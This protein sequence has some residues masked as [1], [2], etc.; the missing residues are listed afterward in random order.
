MWNCWC[1]ISHVKID[2]EFYNRIIR[3]PQPE[4]TDHLSLTKNVISRC[5][6][7][8]WPIIYELFFKK[9]TKHESHQASRASFHSKGQFAG[10]LQKVSVMEK[11]LRDIPTKCKDGSC[12]DPGTNRTTIKV[13][14]DI[15]KEMQYGLGT[16]W[17]C[18]IL[19]TVLTIMWFIRKYFFRYSVKYIEVKWHDDCG[20]L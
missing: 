15:S 18:G 17:V 10:Y 8:M 7:L 5:V 20:L 11:R 9:E 14:F 16:Q 19:L 12:L 13:H 6:C 4:P 3:Q 2:G 1:E